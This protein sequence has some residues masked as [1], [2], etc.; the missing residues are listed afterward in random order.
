MLPNFDYVRPGSAKDAIKH[1]S[2]AGARIHAGGTDL[3][4]CL[5]DGVYGADKVVSLSKLPGLKGINGSGGGLKIGAMTTINEVAT[6]AA[7][8][9]QYTALAQAAASV[10]SP[11]LRNQGT[12]G[13]NICQRPWCWYF[14]GGYDCVRKG[15]DTC[16]AVGG[17]NQY[18]CIFGSEGICYIVHP[19]D[20][21]PALMALGASVGITGRR[22]KRRVSMDKFFVGPGDD[23]QK[24]TI[25]EQDE[26]VTEIVLPASGQGLRSSYR[27]VR[28]RQ[29]FDFALAGVALAIQMSGRKVSAA[30]VV[31]SGAAPVP[32]RSEAAEKALIGQ[33]L[34]ASTMA[35]AAEAAVKGAEPM[36][37]NAYKVPL[38]KGIIEEELAK[39]A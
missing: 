6:N 7:I 35:T 13:G 8:K 1:L 24:E 4:N 23:A 26:I 16:Y 32:W 33:E 39:L 38:F 28:E 12:I 20:T 5:R 17:E 10:A 36:D 34:N 27:K 25:L 22:G 3:L 2:S 21:A 37:N 9:A 18:H 11:Q 31:L 14:R 29:A 15:G 30:S 19:S